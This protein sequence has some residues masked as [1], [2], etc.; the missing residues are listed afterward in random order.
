MSIKETD[1][2]KLILEAAEAEFIEKGYG[3]SRTTEIAKRAGVNHAMLHYYFRTKENLFEVVFKK[4]AKLMSEVLLFSFTMDLPFLE[5][6]KK[7]IE[8]HF[9]LLA[10]NPGL[11]NFIFNEIAH[12]DRL[13]TLFVNVIK[14]KAKAIRDSLKQEIDNEVEK[15][16]IRYIDAYDLLFSIVSLNIFVFIGK[17][18]V[19]GILEL[20][21]DQFLRFLEHRKQV[22]V[23]IIL[24]RL[25][26]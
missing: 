24:N 8:D 16:T 6:I 20:D 21:E 1:S 26:L 14:E 19:L 23:E 2:E 15:G 12:D 18:L 5:K 9:D 17:P 11:P 3:K 7:G 13:R 4:K 22:N 10:K 25:Q